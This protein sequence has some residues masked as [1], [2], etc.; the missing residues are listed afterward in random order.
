MSITL[1]PARPR[2]FLPVLVAVILLAGCGGSAGSPS[3]APTV[4]TTA[5][6]TS[7]TSPVATRAATP[8]PVD[9]G[10]PLG[11][12]LVATV[13]VAMAPCAL[14]VDR[15]SAWVTSNASGELDR[16]DPT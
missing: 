8:I 10:A 2:R 11:D 5:A 9:P 4:T 16:I 13:T 15:A 6:P 12:R 7:V 14:A 3:I 1:R